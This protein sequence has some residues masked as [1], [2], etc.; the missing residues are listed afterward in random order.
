MINGILTVILNIV[1][2]FVFMQFWGIQGLALATSISITLSSILLSVLSHK[3]FKE[4]W[5]LTLMLK[6]GKILIASFITVLIARIAY[7]YTATICD[8]ML[9]K[10]S[11]TCIFAI[12]IYHVIAYL[13]RI[14]YE[15]Q[16]I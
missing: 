14:G 8:V 12:V 7:K 13:F 2:N 15:K 11:I 3:Y 6:I 9:L 16:S 5:T 4:I 1:L 10:L